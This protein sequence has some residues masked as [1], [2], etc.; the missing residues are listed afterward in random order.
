MAK[1]IKLKVRQAD[2]RQRDINLDRAVENLVAACGYDQSECASEW[3]LSLLQDAI[4][5]VAP[6]VER[7]HEDSLCFDVTHSL[8]SELSRMAPDAVREYRNA[9]SP[10][11]KPADPVEAKNG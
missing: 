4:D 3:F 5:I 8:A 11:T 2:R 10:V 7:S 9:Q 6:E 1:R